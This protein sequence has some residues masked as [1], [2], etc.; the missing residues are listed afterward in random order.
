MTSQP[1]AA[2]QALI[3]DF[4]LLS[5]ANVSDGLDRL[6]LKGAPHGIHPLWDGCRKIVGPAATMLLVPVGEAAES[7]VL[8]TLEAVKAGDPGDIL[9]IDQGGRM[10]VNSYGGVAGFTTRHFGLIGCVID[11]VTRDIDE[12]K[13]LGLPVYG[14]GRIQQSIRNRCAF[15]GH[16]VEVQLSGVPVRPKDIVMADDNGVVVVPH[17]RA[18]EVLEFST[19]FKRIEDAVVAEV[20][21]GA[22]P[23][24]AHR[25]VRYDMMTGAGYA[26][27]AAS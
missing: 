24:E 20:R 6:G 2:L 21:R 23:T 13:E 8:G 19:L 26:D 7:P 22:D 3:R 25:Q 9:I 4:G 16:S 5:T 15:A 1:D 11:G 17:D 10:D 27:T 18:A 14:R 12:Y